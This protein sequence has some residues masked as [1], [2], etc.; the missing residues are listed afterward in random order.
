MNLETSPEGT[1]LDRELQLH[2]L[3]RLS[4]VY[5]EGIYQLSDAL[6]P[7][8]YSERSV[9]VNCQYLDGHGLIQSG[10]RRRGTIGDNSF[11]EA[12]EHV[13]TPKG[14]DFLA[15]DG[16]LGAILGVVTVR[17]D[18][19]QFAEMLATKIE[20]IDSISPEERS[21]VADALRRL[22]AKGAEKVSDRLLDWAVDHAQDALPLLRTLIGLVAV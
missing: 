13:I 5:P 12:H 17:V 9:L 20:S 19:L 16:G 8:G 4:A 3:R 18:A 22:P 11:M 2:I 14:L 10:F 1:R 15:E 21:Q 7:A 6:A